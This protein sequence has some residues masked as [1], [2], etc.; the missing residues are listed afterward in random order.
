VP[1]AEVKENGMSEDLADALA[2]L[3]EEECLALVQ[4][5]LDA[6]QDPLQILEEA[7]RGM[8]IVGQRYEC[9]DYFIPE[10]IYA[11]ELMKLIGEMVRPHLTRAAGGKRLG[12]VVLGTVAGDIHD[13]GLNI[14]DLML[15]I[16]GFE[17][18]NLGKDVPA[19]QF[20]TAIRETGA[21]VVG[22]SG[23]LTLAFDAMK[24]TVE[25]IEEAGLRDQVKIMVGG[26]QIDNKVRHY[27]SA[28]AYGEDAMSAVALSKSWVGAD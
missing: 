12:T 24:R 28:D 10:L 1:G 9:N 13:L 22:M 17:V 11:G 2:E 5:R 15:D 7:R 3:A 20:V 27:V 4:S 16:N 26:S 23:L 21:T 19:E 14:V 18:H 25:A 8:E 6:G